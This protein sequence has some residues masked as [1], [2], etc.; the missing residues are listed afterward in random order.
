[1]EPIRPTE[2]AAALGVTTGYASMLLNGNRAWSTP[3]AL[4]AWRAT[5]R[6]LGG[7][8]ALSDEECAQLE[9]LSGAVR[10]AATASEG[11]AA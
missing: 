6:K 11:P 4:K 1:M 5:G 2:L 7:L 10:E 8:E 9:R 3:L